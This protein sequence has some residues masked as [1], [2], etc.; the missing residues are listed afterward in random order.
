LQGW[1]QCGMQCEI[2]QENTV[3]ISRKLEV[4]DVEE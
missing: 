1:S 4:T 3:S 2:V